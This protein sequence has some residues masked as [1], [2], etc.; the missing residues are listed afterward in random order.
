MILIATTYNG[1]NGIFNYNN[2]TCVK[3][4]ND[5]IILL[6]NKEVHYLAIIKNKEI[7][8]K[9]YKIIRD[10]IIDFN[11]KNENG[12]INVDVIVK[13]VENKTDDG[14]YYN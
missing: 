13:Q 6:E 14:L 9:V 10:R 8:E 12:C 2:C 5:T 3:I 4:Q 1:L 11:A 7:R